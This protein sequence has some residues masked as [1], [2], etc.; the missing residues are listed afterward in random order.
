MAAVVPLTAHLVE[1]Q[2]EFTTL[3]N[4]GRATT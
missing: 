2:A 1:R 4:V 3:E